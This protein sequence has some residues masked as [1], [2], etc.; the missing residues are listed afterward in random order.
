MEKDG[1]T[2]LGH[3]GLLSPDRKMA[4]MESRINL[5]LQFNAFCA[6]SFSFPY[7]CPLRV[8]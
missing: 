3:I 6:M 7:I 2:N 8:V 1:L 4:N 5:I